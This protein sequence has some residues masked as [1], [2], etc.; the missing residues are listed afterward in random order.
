MSGL[1]NQTFVIKVGNKETLRTVQIYQ[2]D[3]AEQ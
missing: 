2:Y 3:G 1:D